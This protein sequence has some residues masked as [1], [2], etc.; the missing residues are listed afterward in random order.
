MSELGER[1]G[2][3]SLRFVASSGILGLRSNVFG[4]R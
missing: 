3:D 4:K 2:A 1:I